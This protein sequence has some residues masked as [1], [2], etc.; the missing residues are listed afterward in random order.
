MVLLTNLGNHIFTRYIKT[1]FKV[2]ENLEFMFLS[3]YI[4]AKMNATSPKFELGTLIP[5]SEVPSAKRLARP[6][7]DIYY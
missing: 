2:D 1:T 5:L 6:Y 3:V 7:I 4:S